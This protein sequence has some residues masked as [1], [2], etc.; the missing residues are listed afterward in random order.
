MNDQVLF[1]RRIRAIRKAGKLSRE[2]LAERAGINSN[3]LGEIE[4]GEKWPSLEVI[5]L[6][7]KALNVSVA[8]F[9]DYESQ[10]LN[11]NLLKAKVRHLLED[12]GISEI[13]RAHR[14]LKVLFEP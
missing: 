6:L 3:Y 13:Q 5:A 8:S 4:R 1:G 14:I 7:A 12:R 9:F 2:K 11:V 10:E